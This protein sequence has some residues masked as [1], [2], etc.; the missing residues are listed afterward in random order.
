M[1]LISIY[2]HGT[3]Y[4]FVLSFLGLTFQAVEDIVTSL[5]GLRC[6]MHVSD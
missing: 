2:L 1:A 3:Q 4:M 6:L 5:R